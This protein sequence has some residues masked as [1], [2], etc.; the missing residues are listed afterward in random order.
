MHRAAPRETIS[1]TRFTC[2]RKGAGNGRFCGRL[3]TDLEYVV[4]K[5]AKFDYYRATDFLG[6]AY[7]RNGRIWT[8]RRVFCQPR[9]FHDAETC[10]NYANTETGGKKE[11]SARMGAET[12]GRR[13]GH[14]PEYMPKSRAPWFRPGQGTAKRVS[15]LTPYPKATKGF[16]AAV[17][18]GLTICRRHG[19]G[20]GADQQ[21][22]VVPLPP[23]R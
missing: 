23:G 6:D 8:K 13:G 11:E 12:G 3:F 19:R 1:R 16:R 14:C 22:S 5:D 21:S 20:R 4:G 9:I 2:G 17:F 7:A 18:E 15:G 10:T